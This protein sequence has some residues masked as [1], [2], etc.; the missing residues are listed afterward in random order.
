VS[1]R[2]YCGA[3][4]DSFPS[5]RYLDAYSKARTADAITALGSLRPAEALLLVPRSASDSTVPAIG[6]HQDPE[7][8]DPV[9]DNGT[10]VAAPGFK[11]EKVAVDLLEVGDVVRVQNGATPP[12]DG[13]IVSGAETSFDESSLTGEARPVK[14]NIGDKV[15]LGTIN[16]SQ[17]V[18]VRVDATGG[19]T[20]LVIQL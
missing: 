16:K 8:C 14:K 2:A 7:K 10:F 12:S 4:R 9:F 17:A 5:G 11:F 20:M 15:L 19:V 18:D 13:T 1:S 6:P 3:L